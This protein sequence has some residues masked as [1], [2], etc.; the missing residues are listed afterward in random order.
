MKPGTADRIY[1]VAGIATMVGSLRAEGLETKDS[2]AGVHLSAAKLRSPETR[3]SLNQ[4]IQCCRNAIRLSLDPF[5]AYHTGLLFH[6]STFGMYGFAILS[7]T[8]IR[9]ASRFAQQY[10]HL[11]FPTA[12][13][14]FKE[15]TDYAEWI[16]EPAPVPSVDPPLYKFIV[17]MHFGIATCLHRDVLGPSFAPLELHVTYA[18]ADTKSA[19][20]VFGCP[21]IF[22]QTQNRLLLDKHWLDSPASLGN[23]TTY[24]EL[25]IICD[26]LMNEMELRAGIASSIRE[27]LLINLARPMSFDLVARQLKMSSRTLKRR[28]ADEG[29][30]Y[31]EIVQELRTQVAI[32]YLRDTDLNIEDIASCLGFRDV[33][34]FRRAFRRWT[35]KTPRE[36]RRSTISHHLAA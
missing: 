25:L 28:L 19:A 31:R 18:S 35:K 13:V 7:S 5:F 11:A 30:S 8:D 14:T 32:K 2:L 9:E 24:Q 12:N 20:E 4:A 33:T 34:N 16:I 27:A 3:V 36:F 10:Q 1:R 23:E 22:S 15:E 17:E 26:K 21:V 29:I 6:I